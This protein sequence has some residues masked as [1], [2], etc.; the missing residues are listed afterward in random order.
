MANAKPQLLYIRERIPLPVE[1]DTGWTPHT[2][3]ACSSN[4]KSL[5]LSGI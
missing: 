5:T 1:W 4:G 3:W 2:F